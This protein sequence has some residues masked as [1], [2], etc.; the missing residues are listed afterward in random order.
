MASTPKTILLEGGYAGT[1][2]S[3]TPDHAWNT[4]MLDG[5]HSVR[6]LYMA[7]TSGNGSIGIVG[8][9]F[10]SGKPAAGDSGGGLL[11]AASTQLRIEHSAFYGNAVSGGLAAG[12]GVYVVNSYFV[13]MLDNL[14]VAN[15]GPQVGGAL[16]DSTGGVSGVAYIYN[17]TIVG[18]ISDT[19]TVPAGLLLE[20]N[21]NYDVANNI[22]WNNNTSSGGSDFGVATTN[23]RRTNDIGVIMSGSTAGTVSGELAVDPKFQVCGFLC[24]DFELT[25]SSPLVD[26]GTDAA[27]P[28]D[29]EDL[30]GK[31]R[32]IGPHVDIGAFE[33]DLIFADSWQL[34]RTLTRLRVARSAQRAQ[35]S[36]ARYPRCRRRA[37]RFRRSSGPL[38]CAT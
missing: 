14:F 3:G 37:A 35:Q 29:T 8:L 17:N 38:P 16:I 12:G 15:H 6:P 33:N 26:T 1:T 10:V 20:G 34:K 9:T 18:N 24:I 4:T 7:D 31:P 2:C 25:R 27:A 11:I 19:L 28:W 23:T 32:K 5:Q 22:V 21:V 13:R 30:A 36:C